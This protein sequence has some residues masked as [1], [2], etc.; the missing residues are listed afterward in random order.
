MSTGKF[1]ALAPKQ[2]A[3][4]ELVMAEFNA[5]RPIPSGGLIGRNMGWKSKGAGTDVLMALARKGRLN[6]YWTHTGPHGPAIRF[7]IPQG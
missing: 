4:Y 2:S 5:G 1:S 7:A 3:V 6:W